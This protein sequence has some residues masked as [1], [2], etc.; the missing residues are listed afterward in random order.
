MDD[1]NNPTDPFSAY[2]QSEEASDQFIDGLRRLEQV[3]AVL[4]N[5]ARLIAAYYNAL[6]TSGLPGQIVFVLTRDYANALIYHGY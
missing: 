4:P 6:L 5:H 1:T 2:F 3:E